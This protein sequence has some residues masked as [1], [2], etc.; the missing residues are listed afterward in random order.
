VKGWID[1][2]Q[3]RWTPTNKDRWYGLGVNVWAGK[4]RWT[5]SHGGVLNSQGRDA[6]GRPTEASVV[7]HAFK[8]ADGTGVFIA[9]PWTPDARD[10]VDELRREIGE[11][12]KFVTALP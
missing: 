9:M 5:V 4:G 7:S 10:A 3:T 2:A 1:R 11:T 8:A 12:H 6:E